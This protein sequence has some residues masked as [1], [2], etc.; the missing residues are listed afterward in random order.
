MGRSRNSREAKANDPRKVLGI[1]RFSGFS[2]DCDL[3]GRRWQLARKGQLWPRLGHAVV[4]SF[5][6]GLVLAPAR[7]RLG[8]R[9]VDCLAVRVACDLRPR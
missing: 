5:E 4:T 1:Q 2:I 7:V 9:A 8:G 3:A 6:N